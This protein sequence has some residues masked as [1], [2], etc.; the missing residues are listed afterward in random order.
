MRVL[1]E[2][3]DFRK[4]S[5]ADPK[6]FF[7]GNFHFRIENIFCYSILVNRVSTQFDLFS[8]HSESL[9]LSTD[10]N[11]FSAVPCGFPHFPHNAYFSYVVLSFILVPL[12]PAGFEGLL[13]EP[14]F[15]QVIF[16]TS[17]WVPPPPAGFEGFPQFISFVFLFEFLLRLRVLRDSWGNP[18]FPQVISLFPFPSVIRL[19]LGILRNSS[20]NPQNPQAAED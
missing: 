13:R 11:I 3:H 16:Y 17:L 18:R 1:Q 15:P 12:P 10:F 9:E 7:S 20:G 14:S 5:S 6:I 4:F 8:I 2:I 19:R